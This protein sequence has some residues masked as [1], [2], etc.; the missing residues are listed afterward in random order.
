MFWAS[1]EL[2]SG[3]KDENVDSDAEVMVDEMVDEIRS[4]LLDSGAICDGIEDAAEAIMY[5]KNGPVGDILLCTIER[6][7]SFLPFNSSLPSLY[8]QMTPH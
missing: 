1:E 7:E 8:L 5:T 2:E 6:A 3:E 4:S